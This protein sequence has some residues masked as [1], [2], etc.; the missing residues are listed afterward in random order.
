MTHP[1]DAYAQAADSCAN[2]DPGNPFNKET[3]YTGW[4]SWRAR[5]GW[6]D[7]MATQ[8]VPTHVGHSGY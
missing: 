6:D 8:C 1:V 5:G 2:Y 7:H 3:D 4:S